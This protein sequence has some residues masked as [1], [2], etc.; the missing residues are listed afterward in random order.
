[1][2]FSKNVKYVYQCK[3]PLAVKLLI[4]N[5]KDFITNFLLK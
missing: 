3:L 5:F 1:M 2:G 4:K